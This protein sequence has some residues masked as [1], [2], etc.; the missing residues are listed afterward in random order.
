VTLA[1]TILGTDVA[2]AL[3]IGWDAFRS[4][5]RDDLAGW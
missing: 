1:L 4:A 2:D 3:A 5:A